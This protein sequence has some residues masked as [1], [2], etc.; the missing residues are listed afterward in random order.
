MMM[1]WR[2]LCT[3]Y[4]SA[5]DQIVV[6]GYINN[7]HKL[8]LFTIIP[9]PIRKLILTNA[10]FAEAF[11]NITTKIKNSTNESQTIQLFDDLLKLLNVQHI[12][13]PKIIQLLSSFV[14]ISSCNLFII[15]YFV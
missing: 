8:K 3:K 9:I 7:I 5:S 10:Y 14:I 15:D 13:D 11:P 1:S 4:I 12:W 2:K 6:D